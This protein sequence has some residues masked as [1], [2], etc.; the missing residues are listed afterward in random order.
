MP[1]VRWIGAVVLACCASVVGCQAEVDSSRRPN[2]GPS[3]VATDPNTGLPLDPTGTGGTGTPG[4]APPGA[5]VMRRLTRDEYD[6]TLR[7]IAGVTQSQAGSFP[8]EE[9]DFGF[10]N[11]GAALTFPPTLGDA[12][13]TAAQTAARQVVANFATH[14]TCATPQTPECADQFI[15]EFGEKAWRRPLTAAEKT[16]LRGVFDV[17]NSQTGFDL[18]IEMVTSSMLISAPFFYRVE[19]GDGMPVP[20]KQNL[21][22]PTSWEMASR[23]SY[24]LWNSAPDATLRSLAAQDALKDPDAIKAQ[25]LAMLADPRARQAVANFNQQWLQTGRMNGINKDPNIFPE[26]KTELRPLLRKEI[27]TLLERAAWDSPSGLQ[28][29]L[30]SNT[31][32][33]NADLAKFYGVTGPTGTAFEAVQVDA[34]TRSGILS[35][36][37]L[38]AIDGFVETSPTLRGAYIRRRLLCGEPPPPD[39]AAAALKPPPSA[40]STTRQRSEQHANVEPCKSCHMF[41]DPIGFGLEKYDALGKYREMQNNLPIDDSGNVVGMAS[42][43]AQIASDIGPFKGAVEL[44]QKM[45]A[46]TTVTDCFAQQWFRFTNGRAPVAADAPAIQELGQLVRTNGGNHREL[47]TALTQTDAFL[48]RP[49]SGS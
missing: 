48:Y 15:T 28:D 16:R 25:A 7:D 2:G 14:V 31:T 18:G 34:A 9:T 36:A 40:T 1:Q 46:S 41:I 38:L 20:G 43:G 13:F 22:R 19:V 11:N 39:P 42:N 23:L 26:W 35:R 30:T 44:G 29:I 33:M 12:A 10:N 45:A 37:G 3:P 4:S 49:A 47:I 17:G 5:V 24:F 8:N 21:V 6:N 32:F 27:D